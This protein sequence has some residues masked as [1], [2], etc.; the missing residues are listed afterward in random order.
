MAHH[1]TESKYIALS[2][3][4]REVI[5]IMNVIKELKHNDFKLNEDIPD[6]RSH[7]FEDNNGA[8]EMAWVPNIHPHTKHINIKFHHF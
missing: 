6:F 4:L 3:A 7:S 5:P 2:Q 8:L 1:S